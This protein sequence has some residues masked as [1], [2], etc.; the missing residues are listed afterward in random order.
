M[1]LDPIRFVLGH[2]GAA[3][4]AP[5]NTQSSLLAAHASHAQGV[6]LDVTLLEDGHAVIF[7]DKMINRTSNGE[8]VLNQFTLKEMRS[9]DLGSWFDPDFQNELILTLDEALDILEKYKMTVNLEL[10]RH[11]NSAALLVKQVKTILNNHPYFDAHHLI[12]S[13]FDYSVLKQVHSQ[14]PYVQ[15]GVLYEKQNTPWLSRAKSLQA[16]TILPAHT[17]ITSELADQIKEA[18]YQLVTWTVNNNQEA[19]QLYKLGVQ[20]IITDYPNR[21]KPMMC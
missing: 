3:G 21:I 6:E 20:G 7:H 10:K 2:R 15:I 17:L 14:M 16:S 11:N 19:Q 12:V 8:G 5:E 13:S 9:F 18:G 4:L 1:T